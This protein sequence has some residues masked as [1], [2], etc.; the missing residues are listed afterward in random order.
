M[1]DII[2]GGISE[3]PTLEM[4]TGGHSWGRQLCVYHLLELPTLIIFIPHKKFLRP[5]NKTQN[6]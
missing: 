2:K 3:L 1:I 5:Q 4:P 6:N